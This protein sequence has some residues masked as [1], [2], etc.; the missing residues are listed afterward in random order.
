[1][2]NERPSVSTPANPNRFNTSRATLLIDRSMNWFITIGGLGIIIAVLAIAVF[3]FAQVVPLFQ[4]ASVKPLEASPEIDFRS[5]V[6]TDDEAVVLGLDEWSERPFVLTR[7]GKLS[8]GSA[9]GLEPAQDISGG[10]RVTVATYDIERQHIALGYADGSAQL[11]SVIYHPEYPN[12]KRV[13]TGKASTGEAVALSTGG[14][15]SSLAWVERD[16]GPIVAAIIKPVSGSAHLMVRNGGKPVEDYT[17]LV[18]G[19]P[20]R[21]LADNRGDSLVVVSEAGDVS[22]LVREG[23]SFRAAQ[24]FRPFA[25]AHDQRISTISY[26]YGDVSLVLTNADGLNRQFSLF[27][28]PNEQ[29]RTWGLTKE[30]DRLPAGATFSTSSTRNKAFLLASGAHA[31]LRFGTSAATRWSDDLAYTPVLGAINAKYNGLAL[32]AEDG[33]MRLYHLTDPHPEASLK[34]FFGKVWYEGFSQPKYE[35]QSSGGSDDFEPK[36]SMINLMFGTFKATF[37]ALLFAVPIALFGA[38]YTAEFMHPKFKAV[39]KPTVEIMAALP[40]VVLGFLAA[41]WLAP[42]IEQKFPSVLLVL[43]AVPATACLFGFV[44]SLFSPAVRAKIPA[45]SE[46]L[47]LIPVLLVVTWIAWSLGPVLEHTMFTVTSPDG[48]VVADFRRWWSVT[49]GLAYEQR[50][51]LVV[52]VMMGFAVIPIIFTIAEDSLSNVPPALRSAS[53]AL[54]ASRWQTAIRVVVPTASAGIFSALM[55]GLGRAIG[56]TMIVVMATGNT[57]IIDGNIFN[58][59]RTL[60]ANIAVELPEAP[61]GGTLYRSLFLGALLLFTFTFVVNTVAEIMRS[62]LREKYKTV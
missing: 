51:S 42:A 11:A 37:Y 28:R 57:G 17:V 18:N 26:L 38:I 29:R 20:E 35:W 49:T 30:F 4:G 8:F 36:L 25:D 6:K 40:S 9:S 5:V 61:H 2:S 3:I 27:I 31:S 44:W 59:M 60:S 58:G 32:L 46:F 24:I 7:S 54:G 22:Y 50:N 1:M 34:A 21:V 45:G 19:N 47:L 41:L 10:R 55:I 53:L 39:V 13:V 14:A 15:V 52:G 48:T 33:R 23:E 43:I 16:G 12:G 62:H 56:E